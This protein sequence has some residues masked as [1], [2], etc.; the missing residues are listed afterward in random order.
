MKVWFWF[1]TTEK[2]GGQVLKDPRKAGP[3][4]AKH[5]SWPQKICDLLAGSYLSTPNFWGETIF[6][7]A[8]PEMADCHPEI[9]P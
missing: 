2:Q 5:K 8:I 6:H 9:H 1:P 4:W 7:P 3:R